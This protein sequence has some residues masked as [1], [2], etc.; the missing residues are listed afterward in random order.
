M[1]AAVV[2][3]AFRAENGDEGRQGRNTLLYS[4]PATDLVYPEGVAYDGRTGNF[5]VGSTNGGAVYRGNAQRGNRQIGLFLPAGGDG[6]TQAVGMKVNAQGELFIAGGTTKAV[7]IYNIATGKLI[8]SFNTGQTNGFVNDVALAPDGAAYFTDSLTPLIYRVKADKQGVFQFEV[9]RDLTGTAFQF[10]PGFNL[11]GIVVTG[12]GKYLITVQSN[13]GKLFRIATDTKAVSE[14]K[15]AGGDLM[16]NGDGLLLDG[17]ILHVVRN[18][19][20]LIVQLRLTPDFSAGQQVGS[21]TNKAFAFT[22][23]IAKADDRLLV[24]NSQF[25]RRPTNNP[26]LPFTVAS[27]VIPEMP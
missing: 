13:T 7:W 24:V 15:L 9:W 20:N 21:F 17:Q 14:I 3:L 1:V 11:N 25:D 16:T 6:R 10:T 23:T 2:G 8:K 18:S 19:L 22:T 26:V 27:V 5:F 12:D 4:F